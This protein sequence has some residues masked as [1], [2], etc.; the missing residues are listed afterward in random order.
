MRPAIKDWALVAARPQRKSRLLRHLISTK[1][2]FFSGEPLKPSLPS[3]GSSSPVVR[4]LARWGRGRG[5]RVGREEDICLTTPSPL[6]FPPLPLPPFLFSASRLCSSLSRA[7]ACSL[8]TRNQRY[9]N[10][11]INSRAKRTKAGD[12]GDTPGSAFSQVPGRRASFLGRPSDES[13]LKSGGR[14]F[15]GGGLLNCDELDTFCCCF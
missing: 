7:P 2:F 4:T 13:T 11:D 15:G 9:L 12:C 1:P 8:V 3:A 5:R 6:D 10:G 14:F